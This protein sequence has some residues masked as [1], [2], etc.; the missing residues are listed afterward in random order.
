M[1]KLMVALVGAI[2]LAFG[3]KAEDRVLPDGY[4]KLDKLEVAAGSYIDTAMKPGWET[5]VEMTVDTDSGADE[6]WFGACNG[7]KKCVFTLGK[8]KAGHP[9][10]G[11]GSGNQHNGTDT[12][13]AF[14]SKVD[15]AI[16]YT[17]GWPK[18]S[19]TE[20]T[21]EYGYKDTNDVFRV[22]F[23]LYLFAMNSQGALVPSGVKLKCAACK[24]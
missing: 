2:A 22:N 19:G 1:R 14:S 6:I 7:D 21:K 16:V 12:G 8:D 13:K 11:Y 3:A 15:A 5:A 4:E 23:N 18:I 9:T 20:C 24:I 17:N 10:I